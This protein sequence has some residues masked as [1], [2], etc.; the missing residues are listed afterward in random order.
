MTKPQKLHGEY[1]GADIW[2]EPA[3]NPWPAAYPPDPDMLAPVSG[4][5]ILPRFDE[6]EGEALGM[7][8]ADFDEIELSG[9]DLEALGELS[10]DEL[11]ALHELGF[12]FKKLARGLKKA[13]KVAL[14]VV[15]AVGVVTAFVVP[16][17]GV[18]LAAAAAG[19]DK[20]IAAAEKGGKA[21]AAAKKAVKATKV[22]AGKG[23]P[24]AKQALRVL[25]GVIKQRKA[26][27][28]PKGSPSPAL[29]K[30]P[31]D[32]SKLLRTV[33]VVPSPTRT[34]PAVPAAPG[35]RGFFVTLQGR[36]QRRG[37]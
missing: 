3:P 10:G 16:A 30:T 21:A 33:R 19:A 17:V 36:V 27:N 9:D 26:D 6:L 1:G 34:A 4:D 14:P 35:E 8:G 7:C 11:I 31:I 13:V 2:W 29:A 24:A 15:K 22:L 18:P 12:S 37:V 32:K 28:I 23:D 20:L 5:E 25:S